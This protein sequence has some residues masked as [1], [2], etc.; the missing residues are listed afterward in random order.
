MSK[1]TANSDQQRHIQYNTENVQPEQWQYFIGDVFETIDLKNDKYPYWEDEPKYNASLHL[2][3]V[4]PEFVVLLNN[5]FQ[6]VKQTPTINFE[7]GIYKSQLAYTAPFRLLS[8]EGY[9]VLKSIIK[10]E[11]VNCE[12][13]QRLPNRIR[14]IGYRSKWIRDFNRCPVVLE[15]LTKLSGSNEPLMATTLKSS[16]SHTNIGLADPTKNVDQW[17]VDSVPYVII[18]LTCDMTNTIGG[19]LQLIEREKQ[20]ALKLVAE[21]NG[22]I[23]DEYV[24]NIDF[25]GAGSVIF[26]QGCEIAHRVKP[27]L[28]STEPRITVV[29]SYMSRNPFVTEKTRYQTFMHEST[30]DYEFTLHK[31]W[32]AREQLK[33]LM[34]YDKEWPTKED[35]I[36]RLNLV[37]TELEDCRDLLNG[38]ATDAIGYYDAHKKGMSMYDKSNFKVEKKPINIQESDM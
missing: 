36:K 3:I 20:E 7:Q 17:H 21:Y 14:H 6:H 13:D 4:E 11:F 12:S 24:Q 32:R 5:N 33:A 34:M 23:P 28:S 26:M 2:N 25:G 29:N 9:K 31:A 37:I 38:T 16:Y 27:V 8:D 10:R 19:E 18:I 30:C 35:L 22:D 15:F 1:Q